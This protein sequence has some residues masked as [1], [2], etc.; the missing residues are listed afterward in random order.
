MSQSHATKSKAKVKTEATEESSEESTLRKREDRDAEV[1]ELLA[2][3]DE[4]LEE[5]AQDFVEGFVQKGGE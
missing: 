1:D 5:N 2:E 4:V 3:I